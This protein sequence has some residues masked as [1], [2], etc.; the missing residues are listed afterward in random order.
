MEIYANKLKLTQSTIE[1]AMK[2]PRLLSEFLDG[3]RRTSVSPMTSATAARSLRSP[4]L[5]FNL[6]PSPK[7]LFLLFLLKITQRYH[8]AILKGIIVMFFTKK[9]YC[10]RFYPFHL[11]RYFQ[12]PTINS[13]SCR[14][15]STL[16]IS[17]WKVLSRH[18]SHFFAH[19][20][21]GSFYLAFRSVI[22]KSCPNQPKGTWALMNK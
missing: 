21:I 12:G 19:L 9:F 2:L 5:N 14:K 8:K 6:A 20:N 7:S 3:D 13:F 4:G 10:E 17:R 11:S 15:N 16:E 1:S 22:K 18:H